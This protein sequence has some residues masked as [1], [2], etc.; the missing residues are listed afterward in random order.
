M[1]KMERKKCEECGGKVVRKKVEFTLYGKS[2]GSFPA[3]VCS[4]C[5]EEI[6]DEDTS[7]K[8]DEIARE[9]GLWG[10]ETQAKITKVGSSYAVII[11]KKI[12][13]FAGLEQ[14]KEVHIYPEN[15]NRIV[16]EV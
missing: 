13:D 1:K 11:N 7:D 4:K 2:L 14:G 9:K 12:I 6:F 16:I 10:L 8:I 3:E 15:K 5:G